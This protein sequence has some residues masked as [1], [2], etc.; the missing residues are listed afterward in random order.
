[1]ALAVEGG[2]PAALITRG[3]VRACLAEIHRRAGEVPLHHPP[4]RVTEVTAAAQPRRSRPRDPSG[5]RPRRPAEGGAATAEPGR[6]LPPLLRL[7]R[8]VRGRRRGSLHLSLAGDGQT[9]PAREER[10]TYPPSLRRRFGERPP[11]ESSRAS[12][13]SSP[14]PRREA[15]GA[16][17][18]AAETGRLGAGRVGKSRGEAGAAVIC[19][20]GGPRQGRV[21]RGR[22]G[23]APALQPL[24]AGGQRAAA[25]RAR[26]RSCWRLRRRRWSPS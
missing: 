8:A 4:S 14:A 1:M 21:G 15:A 18:A 6:S 24:V 17:R 20:A 11:A 25:G 23:R 2:L 16:W 13:P 26:A 22:A 5:A 12:E 19:G 7:R 10:A 9:L 3:A